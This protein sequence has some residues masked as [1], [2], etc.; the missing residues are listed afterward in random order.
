LYKGLEAVTRDNGNANSQSNSLRL[1]YG[2]FIDES[3]R[4]SVADLQDRLRQAGSRV[5]WVEPHNL[6]FT[7]RFIGDTPAHAVDSFAQAGR[8]AAAEC[9]AFDILVRGVGAFPSATRARTI[10]LGAGEGAE[11]FEALH[12]ALSAALH[13]GRLA[14]PEPKPFV[15]HCTLG[16]VRDRPTAELSAAIGSLSQVEI[17]PMRCEDLCLIESTLTRSGP[18]YR[19][20]EAFT[21]SG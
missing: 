15:A 4:P 6:H 8:T 19:T 2:V 7:L 5:K 13:A 17:G 12:A 20:I 16:R 14:E 9:A 21:L 18:V 10:W 1:F 3:L 11:A